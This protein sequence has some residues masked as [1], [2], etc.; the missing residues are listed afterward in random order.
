VILGRNIALWLA[1]VQAVLSV[2]LLFGVPLTL[3][4]VGGL[5]ALASV[6]IGI[7][8]N[9]NTPGTVPT[10]ALRTK[11]DGSSARDLRD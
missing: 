1:L 8:A 7:V 2:A 5:E 3:P 6:I 11:P 10:F 4:Q 9:A